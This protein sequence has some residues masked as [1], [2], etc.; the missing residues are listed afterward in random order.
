MGVTFETPLVVYRVHYLI[1]IEET[2]PD[3]S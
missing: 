1:L 3:A 2:R